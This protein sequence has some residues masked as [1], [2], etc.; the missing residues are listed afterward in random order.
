MPPARCIC[1]DRGSFCVGRLVGDG[2]AEDQ[3]I[4]TSI[5]PSRRQRQINTEAIQQTAKMPTTTT[6][7]RAP[8]PSIE[9]EPAGDQPKRFHPTDQRR[10]E[11]RCGSDCQIVPQLAHRIDERPAI[12]P[13]HQRAAG[14]IDRR[15][16]G[17]E[18]HRKDQDLPGRQSMRRFGGRD[19]KQPDAG[20]GVKAEPEQEAERIHMPGPA[21][22]AQQRPEQPREETAPREQRVEPRLVEPPGPV[23]LTET[24]PYGAEDQ[25]V[26]SRDRKEEHGRDYSAHHGP[27]GLGRLEPAGRQGRQAGPV[28]RADPCHRRP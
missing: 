15:H 4:S 3:A 13:D 8:E 17:S 20:R 7:K 22:R 2:L 24:P 25:Q 11:H 12:R 16:A 27:Y 23:R 21:D 18:Q 26:G 5:S 14:A 28:R 10:D 19:S 9:P 1:A 6:P